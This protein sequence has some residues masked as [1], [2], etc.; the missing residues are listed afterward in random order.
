ME[1][2]DELPFG[3]LLEER[4]VQVDDLLRLVVHEVDLRPGDAVPLEP[5][6]Q[7]I[8]LLGR[9]QLVA[10]D[11]EEEFDAAFIGFVDD[12]FDLVVAPARPD[13]LR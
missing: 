5:V 4:L 12:V 10:V 2:D 9:A 6:E 3:G 7:F 13:A 8:L 1:V 11:P